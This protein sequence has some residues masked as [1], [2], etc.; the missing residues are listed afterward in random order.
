MQNSFI[1]TTMEPKR[2]QIEPIL[3]CK[4]HMPKSSGSSGTK[5]GYRDS[6][7]R[8]KLHV[9]GLHSS[10]EKELNVEARRI[11][12]F[13]HRKHLSFCLRHPASEGHVNDERVSVRS[14]PTVAVHVRYQALA[15]VNGTLVVPFGT[16]SEKVWI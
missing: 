10:G 15:Y 7:W 11:Q 5:G 16:G 9:K 13:R 4:S 3:P 6:R 2:Q 1:P 8:Q 12:L 14:F